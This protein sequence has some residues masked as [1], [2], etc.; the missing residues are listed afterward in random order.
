[1]RQVRK[2]EYMRTELL[3]VS[4]VV[5]PG[6]NGPGVRVRKGACPAQTLQEPKKHGTRLPPRCFY[7]RARARRPRRLAVCEYSPRVLVDG[8]IRV[9]AVDEQVQLPRHLGRGSLRLF[10]LPRSLS[11]VSFL[12]P[13]LSLSGS[14]HYLIPRR[15]PRALT[16]RWRRTCGPRPPT[17]PTPT[18]FRSAS[19]KARSARTTIRHSECGAYSVKIRA[20]LTCGGKS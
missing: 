16:R 11:L 5:K 2:S 1:M 10:V 9:R 20:R 4:S 14:F 3:L 7:S 8:R 13:S 6:A 12:I 17:R 18:V 15:R 19:V